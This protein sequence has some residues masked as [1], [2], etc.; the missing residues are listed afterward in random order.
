MGGAGPE[1]Q[2]EAVLLIPCEA[3][4]GEGVVEE[5]QLPWHR[6]AEGEAGVER[7]IPLA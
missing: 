7:A 2:E 5:E 4:Q 1:A 6:A 3:A